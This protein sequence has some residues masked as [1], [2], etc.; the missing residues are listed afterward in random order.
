MA[1]RKSKRRNKRKLIL[2][3]FVMLLVF[4]LFLAI[5]IYKILNIR[6]KNIYILGN[7]FLTDQ[8]IIDI[9]GLKNYPKSINHLSISIKDKLESNKY[10][11]TANVYKN[12]FLSSVNIKIKENYPLFYYQNNNKTVLYNGDKTDEK[13]SVPVVVNQIPDTVYK[14]FLI[15][16]Q[17]VNRKILDRISEIEYLPNEVDEERFLML[18]SDGNHVYINIRKFTTINKYL[19]MIKSFDN[20]KGTLY[21]DSGEYFEVFN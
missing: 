8:E 14:K 3:R 6:I 12:N 13:Y 4:L 18:M 16:M 5:I 9:S 17:K 20:K 10:V 11:L 21:L 1:K 7:D 2:K 15:K 19:E